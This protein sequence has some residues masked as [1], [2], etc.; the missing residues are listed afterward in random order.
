MTHTRRSTALVGAAVLSLVAAHGPASAASDGPDRIVGGV[1]AKTS[2]APW[3]IQMS[4][5][6]SS[7]A[8]GEYCGA[9]LVAANKL[10]TAAHCFDE[11][12]KKGWTFIQGRDNLNKTSVGKTAKLKSLWIHP[13]YDGVGDGT[14]GDIAVV[15]LSRSFTGVKTLPLNT[16]ADLGNDTS[17][18]ATVY[19]WGET[20]GTGAQ[21]ILRKVNVPV[22]GDDACDEAYYD[23][24]IQT[25]PYGDFTVDYDPSGEVCAGYPDGG[26]DACQGDSGGPLVANGR[27][28][29][30]V[31]WGNGCAEAGEPGVYSEV[32]T[33]ADDIKTHL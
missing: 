17:V 13:D 30:V 5:S 2:A 4:N 28:L 8:S 31:S 18:T 7:A 25:S 3:A 23:G 22:M 33:Y 15:T 10:V 9:T 27:L 32:A 26:K 16:D 24:R 21:D 14:A 29:G 11:F 20:L 12:G 6:G 19:G 1:T